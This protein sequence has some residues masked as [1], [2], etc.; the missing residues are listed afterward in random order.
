MSK[1]KYIILSFVFLFFCILD[2]CFSNIPIAN[3]I[4]SGFS[5]REFVFMDLHGPIS[6][7]MGYLKVL[8]AY[9]LPILLGIYYIQDRETSFFIVRHCTRTQYKRAELM[10]I[11]LVTVGFSTI[12]QL[13]DIIFTLQIYDIT[14][15][16]NYSFI[17]YSLLSITI[18]SLFFM[19]V[20]FLYQILSDLFETTL[21]ALLG[22]LMINF[23]QFVIIKF[24]IGGF[25]IPG[26][27]ISTAFNVLSKQVNTAS[28]VCSILRSLLVVGSLYLIS[29][30]V[31]E[32]KDIL[33]HEK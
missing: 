6:N 3:A 27:N 31:F 19:S 17:S 30:L 21:F 15:L 29:L 13:V 16:Q 9:T 11:I 18:L 14:F 7:Y 23:I 33:K 1:Y 10:K 28:T 22:T 8:V 24:D 4:H 26:K 25:W 5:T 2:C 12:H 32:K 20:G